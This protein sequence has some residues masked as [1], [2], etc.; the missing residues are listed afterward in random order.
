[1]HEVLTSVR[2][3]ASIHD[4]LL[5]LLHHKHVNIT[6][7]T[8]IA[9]RQQHETAHL[10]SPQQCRQKKKHVA[11]LRLQLRRWKLE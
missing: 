6:T 8:E 10:R 1:M 4:L 2:S 5:L 11:H 7:P 3:H 9:Q